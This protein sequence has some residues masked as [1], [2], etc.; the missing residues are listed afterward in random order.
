LWS[1]A[2]ASDGYRIE[3]VLGGLIVTDA[4]GGDHQVEHLH[5]VGAQRPGEQP[6]SAK[7]VLG[8]YAP[9]LVRGADPRKLGW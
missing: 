9:L 6:V 8:G 2:T 1:S 4:G 7:R 3:A 5:D